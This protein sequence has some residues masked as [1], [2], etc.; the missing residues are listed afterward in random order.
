M[1]KNTIPKYLTILRHAT[2]IIHMNKLF[3]G[4]LLIA[5]MATAA[6][7]VKSDLSHP[8]SAYPRNYPVY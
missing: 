5:T 8:D 1:N 2:I 4:F 6:C 3:I 7:G